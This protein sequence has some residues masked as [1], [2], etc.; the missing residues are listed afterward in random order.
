MFVR[1]LNIDAKLKL[2]SI[3]DELKNNN[4]ILE[5]KV[6]SGMI[7]IFSINDFIYIAEKF[8][9][10]NPYFFVSNHSYFEKI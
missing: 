8:I 2:Y 9:K 10:K 3:E 6:G 4:K 1:S 7:K 5:S